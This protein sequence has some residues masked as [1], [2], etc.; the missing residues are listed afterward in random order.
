MCKLVD[1]DVN[2]S[3]IV[4]VADVILSQE[5]KDLVM[6][7]LKESDSLSELDQDL[8]D[9]MQ[10]YDLEPFAIVSAMDS[11][12]SDDVKSEIEEI[13]KDS[14]SYISDSTET[15]VEGITNISYDE[16]PDES[17]CK[18]DELIYDYIT[19]QYGDLSDDELSEVVNGLLD[20][21][22]I[23]LYYFVSSFEPTLEQ[24]SNIVSVY[25]FKSELYDGMYYT[26][27]LSTI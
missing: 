27:V 13:M 14:E 3:D 11:V 9:F 8:W 21:G 16:L 5:D 6:L 1:L 26:T 19:N 10:E 15:L 23:D 24:L 7:S 22:D 20:E 2:V 4:A 17:L 12:L 18:G 25:A